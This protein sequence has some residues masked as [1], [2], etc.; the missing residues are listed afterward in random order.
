MLGAVGG[1]SLL[2][3]LPSSWGSERVNG[4]GLPS[5]LQCTCWLFSSAHGHWGCRQVGPEALSKY[6][7]PGRRSGPEVSHL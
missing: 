3:H 6:L 7:E 2:T 4:F 1:L 5:V